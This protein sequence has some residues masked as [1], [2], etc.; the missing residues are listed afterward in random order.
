MRGLA[1]TVAKENPAKIWRPEREHF[2]VVKRMVT[3]TLPPPNDHAL[4]G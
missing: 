4:S 1:A 3:A 2:Q